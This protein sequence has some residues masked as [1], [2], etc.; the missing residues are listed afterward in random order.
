MG[1]KS[2]TKGECETKLA[3][4][5]FC[6]EN[7]CQRANGADVWIECRQGGS[8][9][10]ANAKSMAQRRVENGIIELATMICVDSCGESGLFLDT[11]VLRHCLACWRFTSWVRSCVDLYGEME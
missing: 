9:V 7:S 3:N 1:L 2:R 10:K 11:C 8:N 5:T 4:M 6:G